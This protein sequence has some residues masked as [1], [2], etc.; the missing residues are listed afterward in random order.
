MKAPA[1]SPHEILGAVFGYHAFRGP[2]EA[3]VEHVAQGGDA[4]V[5]MPTGAGKSLCYQIPA[6][7]RPGVGI[8]VSPLIALMQDQV[9]ALTL[10][11]VRA[12]FLNSSLDGATEARV[13]R[14][15]RAGELDL[16][17]L[18]PERL[19]TPRGLAFV[20]AVARGPGI[21]LFAIDEAHCVSS[22][23]HDFRPDYLA[24]SIL[25]ERWPGVPR[26]ALTATATPRTREEIR[27]RLGLAGA[28]FFVSSFDRPNITYRVVEKDDG[29]RQLLAFL[30][31]HRGESGIVYGLSRKKA[32]ETAAW[33]AGQGVPALPY[34]AGLDGATRRRHQDRFLRDEAGGGLVMTAT[35]AFGMG[36]DKPDVRFVAHLDLPKSLEGYY[37]E[38]GRAG[39]DGAPAEAWLAYGLGDVVQLRG[40][41]ERGE[42]TPERRRVEARKLDDMLAYCETTGCRRAL[43]LAYFGETS[44]G[45]GC[46]NCDT[47]LAPP[48]SFDGTE[49]AQKALSA[50][51]RTGQRF[52]ALHLVD[53]LLGRT[54]E[55]I[56]RLGHDLL[57]TFGIGR[58]RDEREWRRI[59]RQLVVLG[60]LEPDPDGHGGLRATPAADD[61]LRGRRRITLR[62]AAP[63]APG[64]A[65][66]SRRKREGAAAA[67]ALPGMPA[68]AP[69]SA[70]ES[71][72]F[73]ALREWR[74]GVST[75]IGKPAYVVFADRTLAEIARVRPRALEAL[76]G[77]SG[78]GDH[79]LERYG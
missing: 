25:G 30:A 57:P 70:A 34:H 64:G 49:A 37:Q 74:R 66:R 1:R 13:E 38:T 5:L 18:A 9:D 39:R 8:V 43:L 60:L 16:V 24:L 65:Q 45:G 14:E 52:G 29:R 77:V 19:T 4:I 69:P 53:V 54:G 44:P 55:R 36:I 31:T 11:G 71:A 12:A 21:A 75:A 40:F 51:V 59:L 61:V 67:F 68:A 72:L 47:C 35:I 50:V 58:D 76:R 63:E 7:A 3:I 42:G 46:G 26:L 33:L 48:A 17:Y 28:P 78:V 41:I 62:A 6:L 79:K 32:D 56:V 73:E 22:W 20:D 10:L 2:Q 23:G 15:A 27:A